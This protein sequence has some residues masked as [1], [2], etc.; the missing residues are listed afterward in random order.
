MN[1]WLAI[2]VATVA[3]FMSVA[4][5]QT[6]SASRIVIL[7]VDG[8]NADLLYRTMA[9]TD[10]QTGKSKLPWLSYIF[11][12]QGTIL[13]NF[14]TRGISLSAPS[15]SELDTG[16]H[17]VIRGNV[18]YD[19]YTGEAHDYLNFFPFYIDVAR[20][21]R[22]DMPGVQVLNEAGIPLLSDR[23]PYS[24]VFQS[25][26]LFSRGV[27]WEILKRALK[28]RFSGNALLETI[29]NGSGPSLDSILGQQEEKDL[30]LRLQS[31]K[32]IYGDYYDGD[33]DHDGHASNDPRVL[34]NALKQLD[35]RAG[36]IWSAIQSDP[37][38]K[39]TVFVVVSDHG[40]NNVPGIY[41]QGF[42]LPDLLASPAGGAHHVVTDR[43]QL[44][45]FKLRSI[46]PLLHRV[47]SEST[48]SFYLAGQASRYP[49]A[50]LDLDGNERASLQLRN[51]DLNEIHILL[52]QLARE[53]LDS[54]SRRAAAKCLQQVIDRNRDQWSAEI[55][56]MTTEL[57]A[58]QKEIDRLQP[59]IDAFRKR[60]KA[61][62][63]DR[64]SG[65]L[66]A[67]RRVF[68]VWQAYCDQEAAYRS[69][70]EHLHALLTLDI[71]YNKRFT[72]KVGSYIP[73]LA[74][75]DLNSVHQLQNYVVGPA[76]NGLVLQPDGSLDTARSF[77]FVNYYAL[78]SSARVI[79][80][81]Q[82]ELSSN[83]IDFVI[84]PL[85]AKA[86]VDVGAGC[87][88]VYW[89]Y[90]DSRRQLLVLQRS[91]GQI[92]L[93]P[94]VNL[95]QDADGSFN[96][97]DAIWRAGLP[98]KLFEDPKLQLAPEVDRA[99]WLSS[100]HPEHE[101]MEAIHQCLYSNSVISITEQFSPVA[102]NVPG[103]PGMSPILLRFEKRRRELVQPDL[104]IFAADHWNFDA[105][106]FNPGGNHGSFFR[107]STH[108]VWMMAGFGIPK[109]S[110]EEPCDSLNFASTI[111]SRLGK[112]PPMPDRVL[113]LQ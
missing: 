38:G 75:G 71:P 36:R 105:R 109:R 92:A 12:E 86:A 11:A 43:F 31:P 28:A 50:W 58:V 61:T 98:L 72:G 65:K 77:R 68:E 3:L 55:D 54:E 66:A 104:Q 94:V 57:A 73:E 102:D 24:Q 107:I 4:G 87:V 74:L 41:S 101:W 85:P 33:V 100:F 95:R 48:T 81:P 51:S 80:N 26:Q 29:E 99:E 45:D 64:L 5:A 10:P 13:R 111:L 67:Q 59:Q 113:Q 112:Q 7:K 1:R 16:R 84:T 37:L 82:P 79:N 76:A 56:Q 44:S 78:L 97:D 103:T 25:P 30:L 8:L 14:Y 49:T 34:E 40:M 23:F 2:F 53:D 42:N 46:D 90:A 21:K 52:L 60:H 106:N 22:D 110:I 88:N 83:P 20:S 89:V 70:I 9:E 91:D 6:P 96:W 39:Q 108:S 93:R 35:A 18:E 69:Y 19:R 17:T 63:A 47:I 15:W 62:M 32:L 27:R